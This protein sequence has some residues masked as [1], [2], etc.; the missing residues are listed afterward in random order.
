MENIIIDG[1]SI[2]FKQALAVANGHAVD[3]QDEARNACLKSR[4]EIESYAQD[5]P[6]YGFSRGFGTHQNISVPKD[7]QRLLQKNLILTHALSFGETARQEVVNMTMFFRINALAKAHSGVRV[8]LL[9]QLIKILNHP[10]I[11]PHVPLIGSLGASGD[12]S[13][14]SH[15]ALTMIGVGESYLKVNE[16]WQLVPSQHALHACGLQSITL[17]SK[18][19]LALN[20]GMQ[21][22]TAH[23]LWL[24]ETLHKKITLATLMAGCLS[25]G[26]LG[27]DEAYLP[28]IHALRPYPGQQ[29]VAEL[30]RHVF[31]GSEIR[32]AHPHSIDPN[33]QD[34]YS[35]RCLPQ[36]I[37]PF[38][39]AVQSIRDLIKIEANAATDN[40]LVFN[41][42][43]LSGGNFHGMP[44]AIAAAQL[45][46]TF[47]GVVKI[48]QSIL[49]RLI[50]ADKNRILSSC[51]IDFRANKSV[52]SGLMIAEYSAH[53]LGHL[54]LSRNSTAFLHSVS[55]AAGQEDHVSHVP[56]IL[57]NLESTLPLFDHFL[58]I[59]AAMTCRTY[60]IIGSSKGR[61]I[62]SSAGRITPN[63]TM[64]PGKIGQALLKE[65]RP[66]F[67]LE[68]MI[69]DLYFRV[70]I[71]KI[72]DALIHNDL[73]FQKLTNY[74]GK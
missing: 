22:S 57:Y 16:E 27:S 67:E 71:T 63:A 40:P 47:C 13:P 25:E 45:F 54:I 62:L 59:M 31:V 68:E 55:S 70:H 74:L 3:L 65:V 21:F 28:E 5:N 60:Q 17:E 30:L 4:L 50:D 41:Q 10:N 2:D 72:N 7:Q 8:E 29:K 56:T 11:Y 51:L 48:L 64:K 9:E 6:V 61:Q 52:S 33:V 19:G 15:I 24:S 23:L 53:A 46:N 1:T 44:I 37:G 26:M 35:S 42:R 69:E 66:Y 20:N 38:F 32:D 58:S 18:E 43:V 12:L 49:A 34:P 73:L 39:D 14:L 36:V